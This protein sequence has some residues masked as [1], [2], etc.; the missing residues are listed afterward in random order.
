MGIALA[1]ALVASLLVGPGP[2]G[3]APIDAGPSGG[4]IWQGVIPSRYA[5]PDRLPS[6]VYLP[7]GVGALPSARYPLVVLLHG[8]PGAPYSFSDGLQLATVAD[9]LIG[10]G[11]V[12]PFVAVMPRAGPVGYHGEWAGRWEQFFVR[13][14]LPWTE[15]HLPATRDHRRWTIAG[16]SSG[17][18]GAVD[19]ALRHPR[20][21]R[22]IESWS[23]YYRPYRDGPLRDATAA[24]MAAHDP[25]LLVSREAPLLRSLGTRFFVSCGSMHDLGNALFTLAF[26]AHLRALRLPFDLVLRPGG[27]NGRFWR[28]Q[29]PAALR[30]ALAGR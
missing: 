5:P 15:A 25:T 14:V 11:A 10:S 30:Y 19:I 29:L 23:G 7:P 8:F 3:F 17:G 6:L 28:E 1:L 26:A 13:D 2:P 12:P 22:A 18:Y 9:G 21:F 16:L 24:E 4:T 27:H 20:L